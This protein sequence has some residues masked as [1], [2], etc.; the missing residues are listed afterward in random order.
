MRSGKTHL[1][2]EMWA[3]KVCE[4]PGP[5]LMT[6]KSKHTLRRNVLNPMRLLFGESRIGEIK[7]NNTIKMFGQTVDV[8]CANDESSVD[9]LRG[10]SYGDAYGDEVPTWPQSFFKMLQSRL[11]KKGAQF[12]GTYNPEGPYHWL[13]TDFIDNAD[14]M[15]ANIWKFHI[16]DNIFLDPE[17]VESL[18]HE[19][20]GVWYQRYIEGEW[21]AAEGLIYF[22]LQDYHIFEELPAHAF[23]T[24]AW[25]VCDY[26]TMNAFVALIICLC[27][28]GVYRVMKEYR[29]DGRAEQS[30]KADPEYADE[31]KK[32]VDK[33][34][35]SIQA[36][37]I[38]PS[39]ASFIT[40][41]KRRAWWPI[42]GAIN[43]VLDGI[44]WTSTLISTGRLEISKEC[45]GLLNEMRSYAWDVDAGVRTGIDTPLKE[46]D[47]GPDALRYFCMTVANK[48]KVK[49]AA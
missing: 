32:F 33:F 31:L 11:D 7:M 29:W 49:G 6:A 2:N 28:D 13:K 16:D 45:T 26:G 46:H 34:G 20:T 8:I 14:N 40:E 25:C 47:H 10:S 35:L 44:R 1:A 9:M 4:N 27:S 18:K 19:Y 42:K 17:F 48:L 37:I 36:C 43:D 24:T 12:L 5:F 39:A 30:Q 21:A 15:N 3:K 22:M 23:P 38:D 41:L